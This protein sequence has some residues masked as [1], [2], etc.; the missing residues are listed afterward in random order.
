[1]QLHRITNTHDGPSPSRRALLQGAGVLGL[2]LGLGGCAEASTASVQK[3]YSDSDLLLVSLIQTSTNDFMQDWASGSRM[4]ARRSGLPLRLINSN[5]D[6]SQ[7]YAQIQSAA[8]SG[9][10]ILVSLVA[11]NSADIPGLAKSVGRFGGSL[12]TTFEKPRGFTPQD[13]GPAWA[14]HVGFSG[15]DMGQWVAERLCESLGG[16]GGIIALN[17]PLGSG[18]S[19][20]RFLGLKKALEKFPDIELLGWEPAN[21]DRQT[22]YSKTSALLAKFPGKVSGIWT[23]SDSMALGAVA[24]AGSVGASVKAVGIDGLHEAMKMIKSGGPIVATWYSDGTY[25]G[26]LGLALGHAVATGRLDIG[27]MTDDQRN[28][29]YRQVGVDATNVDTFL[30]PPTY[31]SMMAEMDKGLFSHLVGGP[32]PGY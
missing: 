23:G 6:S 11:I 2:G 26:M 32:V 8:A 10:R 18:Q 21:W 14:A 22:A 1:M 15:I 29:T 7:Q 5:G 4:Y 24:A 9:K 13:L 27:A 16:K 12:V 28:G 20:Q 31:E 3:T 17:G 25:Y 30:T 19:E